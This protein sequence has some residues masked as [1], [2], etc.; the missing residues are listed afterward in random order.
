[1]LGKAC[2]IDAMI[3]P[4]GEERRQFGLVKQT[5]VSSTYVNE[6]AKPWKAAPGGSDHVLTLRAE[7]CV[8]TVSASAF[9]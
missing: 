5:Q 2:K 8:Y 3:R 7:N 6:F 1:M 9:F 4:V